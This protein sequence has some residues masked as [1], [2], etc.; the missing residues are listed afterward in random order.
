MATNGLRLNI[1]RIPKGS[2]LPPPHMCFSGFERDRPEK[3]ASRVLHDRRARCCPLA[4]GVSDNEEIYYIYICI[5]CVCVCVWVCVTSRM[6]QRGTCSCHGRIRSDRSVPGST[7][8]EAQHAAAFADCTIIQ[9]GWIPQHYNMNSVRLGHVRL[10][11]VCAH[12]RRTSRARA[13]VCVCTC[14]CMRAC[15]PPPIPSRSVPSLFLFYYFPS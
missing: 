12:K 4:E 15:G 13:R 11:I 8:A 10:T 3:F 5:I 9:T 14:M 1:S 2:L 6:G 7:L